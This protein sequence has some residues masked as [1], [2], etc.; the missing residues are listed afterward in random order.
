MKD[1]GLFQCKVKN[2]GLHL[3]LY[4]HRI[5]WAESAFLEYLLSLTTTDIIPQEKTGS[6]MIKTVLLLLPGSFQGGGANTI[7]AISISKNVS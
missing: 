5:K 2:L 6:I 4:K 1:A 3:Q 7:F